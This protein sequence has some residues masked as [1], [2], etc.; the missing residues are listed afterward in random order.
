M[1]SQKALRECAEWLAYCLII[2]WDK[3]D[4]DVLDSLWW[5]YHDDRG[6]LTAVEVSR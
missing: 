5:R 1:K 2:G 4:L 3:D 6:H